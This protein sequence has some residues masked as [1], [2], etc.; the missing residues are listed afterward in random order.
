M[1]LLIDIG[2]TNIKWGLCQGKEILSHGEATNK[3]WKSLVQ[4]HGVTHAVITHSGKG[5]AATLQEL[6][7]LGI[8]VTEFNTTSPLPLTVDYATPETLGPDR[9][10][11]ACGAWLQTNHEACVIIDGGTCVTIDY[12]DAIGFYRG[13]AILPG[14]DMQLKAL[15]QNTARLPLIP[16]ERSIES[17][18]LGRTTHESM[19][20]GTVCAMQFAIKE[21]VQYYSRGNIV[22]KVFVTGGDGPIIT[23]HISNTIFDPLL[24]LKGMATLPIE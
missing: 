4:T 16:W 2:N 21:F 23:S 10:A 8:P 17:D 22:P 11:A 3:I 24:V 15:H 20:A 6:K 7:N 13:G 1:K 12:V 19:L 14:I 9:L 18:P 5:V